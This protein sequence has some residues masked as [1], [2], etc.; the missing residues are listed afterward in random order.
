M[1]GKDITQDLGIIYST[2]LYNAG[3]NQEMRLRQI[4]NDNFS[5]SG[6]VKNASETNQNLDL[7]VD[8]EFGFDY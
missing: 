1:L 2:D 6:N 7:G 5:V 8:F 4:I 3:N